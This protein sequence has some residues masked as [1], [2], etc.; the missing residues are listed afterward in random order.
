MGETIFS[1]IMQ[2]KKEAIKRKIKANTIMISKELAYSYIAINGK[3]FPMIYGLKPMITD[4]LPE[5]V[6]FA[7]LQVED[8]KEL[9]AE[10][11]A[12]KEKIE[13]IKHLISAFENDE[14]IEEN[15]SN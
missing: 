5:N 10:N 4:E 1:R 2:A 8:N 7:I 15:G 14:N 13:H 11:K 9:K 6:D 3:A 12:L